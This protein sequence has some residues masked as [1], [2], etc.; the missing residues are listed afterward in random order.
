MYTILMPALR[1]H[2]L[3]CLHF[4]DGSGYNP[5]FI[6]NLEKTLDAAEDGDIEVCSGADDI[7]MA[8][9]SLENNVCNN[10]ENSDKEIRGMDSSAIELLNLSEGSKIKWSEIRSMLHQMFPAWHKRYC[11]DCQW[12]HTCQKLSIFNELSGAG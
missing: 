12:R 9:P 11:L 5:E 7:C 1:G 4:F 6:A 10:S 8:C 3:I 2:H